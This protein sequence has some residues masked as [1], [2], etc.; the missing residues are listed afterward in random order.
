MRLVFMGTPQFAV[1]V[2]AR[3]IQDGHE[4]PAVYTQPD[5]P[6]GRGHRMSMPPVKAL[7][8]EKGI[9]VRQP[10]K[11][12]DGAVAEELRQMDLD[13]AVVVAYGRILP[14]DVLAAPKY[15]CVNLHASLL[16]RHRG[17]APIQ[18]SILSGDSVTGVTSMLMDEGM[19]TGDILLQCQ[20][21]IGPDET[22]DELSE[23]LCGMGAQ[24]IA[25]TLAL[26]EAGTAERIP[27]DD[28][29]ATRAPMLTKEMGKIDFTRPAGDIHNQ[30]RGLSGWPAAYTTFEGKLLKVRRTRVAGG[31]T[32]RPGEVLDSKRLIVACGTGALELCEV[33]L[34]G[35]QTVSG[36]AF[37]NGHRI[38][39]HSL[40]G[41]PL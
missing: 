33:Q 11:L 3:L 32:G 39:A 35:K 9:P 24:C 18:W 19:D 6:V 37:L 25:E 7:A 1:P 20:T 29:L 13:A 8:L 16:P 4:I 15:G 2:L 27:Q 21:P 31:M 28:S 41:K 12:R 14:P 30:V 22:A 40:L 26:L 10:V 36:E 38:A 34:E 17:A 23:R 5:K